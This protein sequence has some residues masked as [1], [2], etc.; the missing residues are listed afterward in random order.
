VSDYR[1][2]RDHL[3]EASRLAAGMAEWSLAAGIDELLD[4]L[5]FAEAIQQAFPER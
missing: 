4:E 5:A 2:L 3:E 1:E